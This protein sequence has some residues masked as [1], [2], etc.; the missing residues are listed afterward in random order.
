M[1]FDPLAPALP[2]ASRSKTPGIAQGTSRAT[3]VAKGAANILVAF[4]SAMMD[5]R[6][7]ADPHAFNPQRPPNDY[8][9]FGY[10]LHTCFGIH[11]NLALL[12][13]MLKP[14]LARHNLRR[15]PGP[16]GHL[17]KTRRLRRPT[18]RRI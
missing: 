6:R 4:S 7:I 10:G 13:L 15:A 3:K 9:H 16:A 8:I 2:R 11:M 5:G 14:L 18:V 1:R 12:P 17:T